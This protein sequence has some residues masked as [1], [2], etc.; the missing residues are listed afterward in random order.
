MTVF[1]RWLWFFSDTELGTS[2][3]VTFLGVLVA[4][5]NGILAV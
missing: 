1:L 2:H 3:L 5:T 4:L